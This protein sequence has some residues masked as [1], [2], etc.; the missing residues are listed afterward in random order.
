[1]LDVDVTGENGKE[2]LL[3]NRLQSFL[4]AVR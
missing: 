4:E 2:P 1:V 3:E